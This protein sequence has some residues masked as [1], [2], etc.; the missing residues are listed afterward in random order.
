M[1]VTRDQHQ[2]VRFGDS[3]NPDIV[4]GQRSALRPQP[5]PQIP[6]FT[7]NLKVARQ[8]ESAGREALD[9]SRVLDRP[10]R[11]RRAKKQ[12]T[13]CDCRDEYLVRA[14][15]IRQYCLVTLA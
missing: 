13:E 14:I 1:L 4:L 12:F 15:E 5:L 7:S 10:S 2:V 3:G 9:L 6:I 11:F 8:N